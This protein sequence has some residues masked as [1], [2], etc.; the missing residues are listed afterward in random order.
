LPSPNR[1]PLAIAAVLAAGSLAVLGGVIPANASQ[2]S[3]PAGPGTLTSTSGSAISVFGGSTIHPQ[4]CFT[5]GCYNFGVQDAQWSPDGSRAV[6]IDPTDNY[7]IATVRFNDAQDTWYVADGVLTDP[8]DPTF[9][10]SSPSYRGS[11][12]S[13]VFAERNGGHWGI[14]ITSS[15]YG[16]LSDDV[17]AAD[18]HDYTDPDGGPDG[19]VVFERDGSEVVLWDGSFPGTF[20]DVVAGTDP[21]ISPDGTKVAYVF[22]G[23]IWKADLNGSNASAVT[24]DATTPANPTWSG[25]GQTIAFTN[26]GS[27]VRTVPAAASGGL[28]SATSLTGTPAYRTQKPNVAARLAG[29]SRF[30]TAAAVSGSYWKTKGA[31]ADTR[32]EAKAVVLSRSDTF[33]DALGGATLAAA[34]EGP[35]LLTPP[36]SLDT[37]TAAEIDRVLNPGD[38]VYVLGSTGA[39]SANVAN[40]IAAKGYI[41]ERVAGADRFGTAV[42]IAN[43][44][45]SNPDLILVATGMNFP[46][47][48]GA[49]AAAGSYDVPGTGL[50]AVVVLTLDN[51]LPAAT[52]NYLD[53][54]GGAV[55]PIGK[56]GVAATTNYQDRGFPIFGNDRYET[57]Y[58]VSTAFFGGQ[59]EVGIATGTNWPDALSGGAL[60]GT[61]NGPLLL[62]PGTAVNTSFWT[63][64]GLSDDSASIN[65]VLVFGSAAVVSNAQLNMFGSL[66]SGPGGYT[67]TSNVTFGTSL[68]KAGL[69]SSSAATGE[70]K[71]LAELKAA[72]AALHDKR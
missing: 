5:G 18:G 34:K 59:H 68:V 46:D 13:V 16:F 70:H 26:G 56:Q 35:L 58:Y 41:V 48:L 63:A 12:S 17:T 11:G 71:T 42:A 37:T 40:L 20:T 44:I 62:T 6:F 43:K 51:T 49:G 53:S 64:V 3:S 2:P 10:R 31:T 45:N 72:V 47:A 28:S 69:R 60:M 39:I 36:T 15:S 1:R 7:A 57:A 19:R 33:A 27:A 21:A 67:T 14:K 66:I 30:G 24:S 22:G 61:L 9:A 4:F 29:A 55:F 52:K 23:Q 32:H 65:T 25:D 38:K 8:A 50:T 54:H